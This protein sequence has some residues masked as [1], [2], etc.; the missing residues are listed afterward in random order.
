MSQTTESYEKTARVELQIWQEKMR[1]KPS[2]GGRVSKRIQNRIN[3]MI[4]EKV[5]QVITTAIRET[6]KVMMSGGGLINPPPLTNVSLEERE[7]KVRERIEFYKNTAAA[8]GAIT[9]AGGIL[10][11]LADFPLWLSIKMKLLLEIGALYGYDVTDPK[12]RMFILSV[13][14][15]NFSSQQHRNLIFKKM[16]TWTTTGRLPDDILKT[17]WRS[18]QQEYRDY[19]DLAKLLQLVPGIGAVVGAYVNHR[20]TDSLGTTAI[21]AYRMRYFRKVNTTDYLE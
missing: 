14:Q 19:I 3:R 4:P 7:I 1:R 6:V 5:H 2:F 13:F 8:E 20:L 12:E 21:N 10:F 17:D 11:G 9:G 18:F 15:L 16:D